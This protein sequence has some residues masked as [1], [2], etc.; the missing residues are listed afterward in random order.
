MWTYP[1]RGCLLGALLSLALTG[2]PEESTG[3]PDASADTGGPVCQFD[4]SEDH[5]IT[6]ALGPGVQASGMLCPVKDQDWFA[7]STGPD[8]HLVT[9]SLSMDG[10]LSP[11]QPSY[12]VWSIKDGAP[13]VASASPPSELI[14]QDLEVTHC[15]APGSYFLAVRDHNDDGQDLRRNYNVTVTTAPDPDPSEPNDSVAAAIALTPGETKTGAIACRGDE[16]YY[17]LTIPAA[18]LLRLRFDVPKTLYEPTVRLLTAEGDVVVNEINLSGTV[19]DTA[20]DRYIVT[21]G[22]GDYTL[23]VSDDDGQDADSASTYSL[24]VE[25]LVDDDPNEPNPNP[26]LATPLSDTAAPCLGTAWGQWYTAT[27]T[28]GAPGDVD[29]F[30]LPTAACPGGAVQMVIE[31]EVVL[32]STG[33]SATEQ[34]ALASE[35]QA[36]IAVV[37]EDPVT[38][39]SLDSECQVLNRPCEDGWACAGLFNTCL[40]QGLCAGAAVCLPSGKCGATRIE[41]H[42]QA[43]A[44]TTGTPPP[45]EARLTAPAALTKEIYLRVSDFQSNGAAPQTNYTLRVRTRAEP[46]LQEPNDLYSP[47][48]KAALDAPSVHL[49]KAVPLPVW[50]CAGGECCD[51]PDRWTTG[52]I[53][54]ETDL[55]WFSY[56][57]PCPGFDCMVR[58]HVEY[59]AGPVDPVATV[60]RSQSSPWFDVGTDELPEQPAGSLSL[61]GLGAADSCF[62]SFSGHT[63]DP[64]NYYL[65]IND[66]LETT[67]SDPSQTYRVCIEKLADGCQAPCVP[68]T[69]ADGSIECSSP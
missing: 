31:A 40:P 33:L 19:V 13:D 42:F 18:T 29:F 43:P 38:A 16:D 8:D 12:A 32:D 26:K 6:T 34:W 23:V 36:S 61:G 55:D 49:S 68:I 5:T 47:S 41:R 48:L 22:P 24:N 69:L 10:D 25:F 14:G 54:H 4:D 59:D 21:P 2:C 30:V 57:H 63:G 51:Q 64:F 3:D 17:S 27:G 58:V 20:V 66:R 44:D 1:L 67:D 62:Y 35:V 60:Y 39:C 56:Q 37:R 65:L 7:F 53:A 11:V 15:M 46:D 52:A 28:I 9:I 50:D 45:N